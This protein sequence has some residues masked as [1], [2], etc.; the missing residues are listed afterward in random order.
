ML[1]A[2]LPEQLQRKRKAI[3]KRFELSANKKRLIAEDMVSQRS[4]F[5]A[6]KDFW[7]AMEKNTGSASRLSATY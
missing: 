6:E 2:G 3:E 1:Q 7:P 5:A 4:Q